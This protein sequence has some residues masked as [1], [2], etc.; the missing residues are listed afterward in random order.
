[1]T[2]CNSKPALGG[3]SEGLVYDEYKIVDESTARDSA[4]QVESLFV[5]LR[6]NYDLDGIVTMLMRQAKRQGIQTYLAIVRRGSEVAGF[7]VFN[8]CMRGKFKVI[9]FI[10]AAV[11]PKFRR[12]GVY[13][14]ILR[15][16]DLRHRP[17]FLIGRPHSPFIYDGLRR[18][19]QKI[20]PGSSSR[21]STEEISLYSSLLATFVGP[22]TD[23][24]AKTSVVR[25]VFPKGDGYEMPESKDSR[26]ARYFKRHVT[27]RDALLVLLDMRGTSRV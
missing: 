12:R 8:T 6:N 22:S 16:R 4:R 15:E 5:Y 10:F 14:F 19:C 9:Y 26:T 2:I 24:D 1:M 11:A 13:G 7:T 17:D 21:F 20:Y 23:Y 25:N 27:E 18:F 3:D